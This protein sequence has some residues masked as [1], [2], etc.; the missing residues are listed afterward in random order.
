M[1]IPMS[2]IL[3]EVLQ[4][5]LGKELTPELAGDICVEL[6]H[7]CYPGPLDGGVL[8]PKRVGDYE[9]SARPTALVVH[10]MRDHHLLH[11]QETETHRH[12][13]EC[14]PDYTRVIEADQQGLYLMIAVEHLPTKEY[15]GN[16]GIVM[17]RAQEN[18][19]MC[20]YE[21]ILYIAKE[22]RRGRLGVE[23]IKYGEELVRRL[24][25][26]D[27]TMSA[28]TN[29]KAGSLY[30]RLGYDQIGALY[31]KRFTESSHGKQRA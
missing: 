7:V 3:C 13:S 21:D 30:L 17:E 19:Q 28:K 20:A 1:K 22:H 27:L 18:R 15:V 16:F 23:L 11:W 10:A 2:T 29:T 6:L 9:I 5:H 8:P 26:S 24:N 4:H 12:D 31:N 14:N 25:I